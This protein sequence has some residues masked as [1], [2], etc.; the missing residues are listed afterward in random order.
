MWPPIT[1]RGAE[2]CSARQKRVQSFSFW[3]KSVQS[4]SKAEH[5]CIVGVR[6]MSLT[7]ALMCRTKPRRLPDAL[8]EQGQDVHM[9][10]Q[11]HEGLYAAG[12]MLSM[13]RG[14]DA[15]TGRAV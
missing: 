14:T 6:N 4:A 3:H 8:K 13:I 2:I 15:S 10:R 5:G 7:C 12:I 11:R 1:A 9:Q